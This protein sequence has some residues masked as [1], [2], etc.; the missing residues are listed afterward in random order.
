M[1]QSVDAAAAAVAKLPSAEA[2]RVTFKLR[3]MFYM[4]STV[5]MHA[6]KHAMRRTYACICSVPLVIGHA[7][8]VIPLNDVVAYARAVRERPT[9]N[10]T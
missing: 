10:D 3:R 1:T 9:V 7:A 5:H 4:Q 8:R 2:R 6:S